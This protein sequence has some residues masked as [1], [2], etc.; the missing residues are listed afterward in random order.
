MKILVTGVKGQLGYDVCRRLDALGI[1]NRGVDIDDFDLTDE[2]AVLQN[3]R[4]YRPD[5]VIHCAAYTNVDKAEDERELC[6]RVNVGGT[7]NIA[8]AAQETGAKLVLIS[9]DYVLSG[10]GDAPLDT[11]ALYAPESVYGETKMR[12]EQAVMSIVDKY[13]IVRIAWAFG[14]NGKNFV[15]TMLR[16]GK[17]RSEVSVVCDQVGSPTF[18][19]DLAVLLCDMV[20]SEKYGLYHATN[21][22][23]VSWADFAAAIMEQGGRDCTVK[24]I[25]SS[26]YPSKARRPANSR[27]KKDCLDRAGF[28]RLP[29]W[30][31][32]LRRYIDILR[33]RGEL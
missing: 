31:D 18:T 15:R 30:Q 14:V 5:A 24:P 28:A 33:E 9:T 1:E 6:E 11:D 10:E 7:R 4:A 8:R 29:V 26:E 13:F 2:N 21:E 27:M 22:G 23:Y 32:A 20:Q 25:P 17:E 3:V 16:L 19:Q 12:A